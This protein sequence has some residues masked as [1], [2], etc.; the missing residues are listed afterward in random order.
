MNEPYVISGIGELV[1]NE[2]EHGGLLG[3]LRGAAVVVDGPTVAWVGPVGELP[4]AWTGARRVEM[5]GR[6]VVPGFVDAHTHLAFAGD[7][8]DEFARR[9]AGESYQAIA[10]GGGGILSTMGATRRAAFEELVQLTRRRMRRMITTGTTALEVKSGY[11]LEASTELRQ[12]EAT[13]A[14]ASDLPLALRRTFLGAHAVPPEYRDDRS[15]YVELV[16]DEMLPACASQADYCDVFVEEGAFSVEEARRVLTAGSGLGLGLRVHAE[17][18]GHTG[19]ARLAAELG[20]ASADHLDYATEEDAIA[21]AEAG[22]AAVLV[23]GASFQLRQRHAPGPMLWA[24]GVTVAL[25][26][27]CN[28]GT[29]Y[30]ESMP[31]V[32]ALGVT[33]VG[34]SVEQAMWAATRGGAISLDMEDRGRVAAGARADLVVLDAPSYRHLAYRPAS[35]LVAEVVSAGRPVSGDLTFV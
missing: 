30:V 8:S 22:T 13:A 34:L 4:N 21:L 7:R 12:L 18:L 1:T 25:A 17:Q 6:A 35:D 19:G 32:V 14:A 20:A 24:N 28:P 10:A 26:T 29:S 2:G 23:P 9:M 3:I 33:Q 5:E 11:G 31:F 16:L 15:G 27:D